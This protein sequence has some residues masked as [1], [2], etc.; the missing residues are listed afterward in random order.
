MPKTQIAMVF[1]HVYH[2]KAWLVDDYRDSA[3]ET[4]ITTTVTRAATRDPLFEPDPKICV[5]PA[6]TAW[7]WEWSYCAMQTT[8]HWLDCKQVRYSCGICGQLALWCISRV[9]RLFSAEKFPAPI[10]LLTPPRL[11]EMTEYSTHQLIWM[12]RRSGHESKATTVLFFP[13]FRIISQNDVRPY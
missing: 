5:R 2:S 3:L 8:H 10:S 13:K 9:Y 7:K 11:L 6:L 4:N 1:I 12:P